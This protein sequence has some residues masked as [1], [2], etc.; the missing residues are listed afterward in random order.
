M[1]A[2]QLYAVLTSQRFPRYPFPESLQD[3]EEGQEAT[4]KPIQ[5]SNWPPSA[6]ISPQSGPIT[7]PTSQAKS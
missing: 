5:P 3:V 7:A 1:L 6:P 2:K 4:G